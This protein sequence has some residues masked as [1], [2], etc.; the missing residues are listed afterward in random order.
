MGNS[1]ISSLV[2][3]AA[4]RRLLLILTALSLSWVT[5][6]YACTMSGAVM[7]V[8]CCCDS[9]SSHSCPEPA[10]ACSTEAMFGASD[11]GCCSFVTTSGASAQGQAETLTTPDLLLFRRPVTLQAVE[12]P[13]LAVSPRRLAPAASTV[14]LYLR[15]GRLLR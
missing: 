12:R 6:G 5:M 10:R 7:Q 13:P 15:I 11:D 9:R 14:P 8:A 1:R 4:V 3:A 2:L